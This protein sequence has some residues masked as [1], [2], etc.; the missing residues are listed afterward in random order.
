MRSKSLSAAL[1]HASSKGGRD[2][3]DP[4]SARVPLL[5]HK[6]ADSEVVHLS[7]ISP[8]ELHTVE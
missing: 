4:R 1:S 7:E 2:Q 5:A 6:A 3:S 8:L